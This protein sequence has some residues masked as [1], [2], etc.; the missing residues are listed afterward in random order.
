MKVGRGAKNYSVSVRRTD[1]KGVAGLCDKLGIV[2]EI[3]RFAFSK[4][5]SSHTVCECGR[6]GVV[7][8]LHRKFLLNTI[9]RVWKPFSHL[10]LF[11][12]YYS[13]FFL[14]CKRFGDKSKKVANSVD[15]AVKLY[16]KHF[17]TK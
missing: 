17:F 7:Y 3:R 12:F 9:F 13:R 14:P 4:S 5:T 1:Q 10:K 11:L 6:L 2:D 8:F 16:K 15:K